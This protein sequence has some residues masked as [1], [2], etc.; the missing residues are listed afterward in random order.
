MPSVIGEPAKPYG[1]EGDEWWYEKQMKEVAEILE[2]QYKTKVR[3]I[4][5]D[6]YVKKAIEVEEFKRRRKAYELYFKDKTSILPSMYYEFNVHMRK[7]A[8]LRAIDRQLFVEDP[9]V[10]KEDWLWAKKWI[11][12]RWEEFNMLFH[13]WKFYKQRIQKKG[14]SDEE[15][16]VS[17]LQRHG[18]CSRT[19]ISNGT[20]IYGER[21]NKALD[22]LLM[23]GIIVMRKE[24]KTKPALLYRL[25]KEER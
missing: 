12:D 22:N 18:E 6:D 23:E 19:K 25:K 24:G 8:A 2:K 21:L 3:K 4:R 15:V 7:V 13:D 11:N 16:I 1:E 14:M 20:H 17:Y 5:Y 10:T 9:V